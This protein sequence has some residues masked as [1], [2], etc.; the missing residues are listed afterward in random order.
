VYTRPIRPPLHEGH[1]VGEGVHPPAGEANTTPSWFLTLRVRHQVDR[2]SP[3]ALT[4]V[5]ILA[6]RPTLHLGV[7]LTTT[8]LLVL[9]VSVCR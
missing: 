9:L 1:C 2:V 8:L 7:A 3:S 5:L 6:P 4:T